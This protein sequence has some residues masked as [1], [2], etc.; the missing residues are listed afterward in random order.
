MKIQSNFANF[1]KNKQ[2]K[3]QKSPKPS[4]AVKFQGTRRCVPG[5]SWKKLNS[6]FYRSYGTLEDLKNNVTQFLPKNSLVV[7]AGCS[8]G[9]EIASFRS[10]FDNPDDYSYMGI[11]VQKDV[12]DIAKK[13]IYT[14][15]PDWFDSFLLMSDKDLSQSE[16]LLKFKKCFFKMFEPTEKPPYEI[17]NDPDFLAKR[18]LGMTYEEFFKIKDEYKNKL[19]FLQRDV[20]DINKIDT[21]DKKIGAVLLRNTFYHPLENHIDE[22]LN[23]KNIAVSPNINRQAVVDEII[24][25]IYEVLLP[26]GSFALGNETKDHFIPAD[27]FTPSWNIMYVA[28]LPNYR[29]YLQDLQKKAALPEKKLF[30]IQSEIEKIK[31]LGEIKLCKKSPIEIAL[32]KD[33]RFIPSNNVKVELNTPFANIRKNTSTVWQKAK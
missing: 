11:D 16:I 13:E 12:I 23:S 5:Q 14:L 18:E 1:N 20:R 10:L 33:G 26:K 15:F 19:Q 25:P 3:I 27:S 7:S 32:Q 24:D 21:G 17:N 8:T 4:Q 9:E 28:D 30:D 31:A 22:L 6:Y 2:S 29:L